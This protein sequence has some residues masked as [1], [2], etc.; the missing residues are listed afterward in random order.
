MVDGVMF[1]C[2]MSKCVVSSVTALVEA[3][4]IKGDRK[5]GC[6]YWFTINQDDEL[7]DARIW[8][9]SHVECVINLVSQ[10]A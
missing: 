1:S 5:E 9:D 10:A 8:G 2:F 4:D 7:P 3:L 6:S